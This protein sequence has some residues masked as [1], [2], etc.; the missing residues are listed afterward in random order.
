[1]RVAQFGVRVPITWQSWRKDQ[2]VAVGGLTAATSDK[3]MLDS[4]ENIC[5]AQPQVKVDN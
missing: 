5:L 3:E 2:I 1:M 4:Y